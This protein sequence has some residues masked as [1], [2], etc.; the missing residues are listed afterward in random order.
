MRSEQNSPLRNMLPGRHQNAVK[1]QPAARMLMVLSL[2]TISTTVLAQVSSNEINYFSRCR[3]IR[4]V[5]ERATC[6]DELYD[7]AVRAVTP[8]SHGSRLKEENRRMR[9]ELARIRG[10]TGSAPSRDQTGPYGNNAS[11]PAGART[12]VYSSNAPSSRETRAEDFGKDEPYV[13]KGENGKEELIG[14]IASLQKCPTGWVV[15]LEKGQVWRQML[16][17]HYLLR[18]G[19]QVRIYPTMWGK[20]YRLS[21][22]D[23]PGYIQ[24][25][26]V[27]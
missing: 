27:Q 26:R 19:Q 7:R 8:Q 25:E 9:E 2:V 10:Q 15:T 1:V 22:L 13:V 16:S 21:V 11:S 20:A 18:E 3:T 23:G 24:V 5:Q 14:R 6:Y 17:K 12:P 4:D